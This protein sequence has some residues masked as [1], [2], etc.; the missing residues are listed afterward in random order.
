MPPV[1]PADTA[2]WAAPSLTC[3][4]ATRME[5]SFFRAKG[6]FKRVIHANHLTGQNGFG[7]GMG[8][9]FQTFGQTNQQQSSV[10]ATIQ[11]IA[12]GGK[13]D[14]RAMIASHAVNSDSD[15]EKL[16]QTDK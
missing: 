11:K 10:G 9:F 16:M 12:A 1:L 3:W 13:C 6:H 5:E 7:A 14:P 15:H 2:A 4:I 8:K